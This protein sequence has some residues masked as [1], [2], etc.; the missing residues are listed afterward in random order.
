M[1]EREENEGSSC[2][3][4]MEMEMCKG[5]SSEWQDV[6]GVRAQGVLGPREMMS[7]GEPEKKIGARL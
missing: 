3:R 4:V 1:R 7:G 5:W 2:T 6:H